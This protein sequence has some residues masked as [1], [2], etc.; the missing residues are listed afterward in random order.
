MGKLGVMAFQDDE[1]QPFLGYEIA[2]G[3]VY[4]EATAAQIDNEVQQLLEERYQAVRR[5][6]LSARPKLD[7][8]VNVLLQEETVAQ[9]RLVEILGPRPVLLPTAGT[10]TQSI[11]ARNGAPE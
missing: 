5:L 2:Q 8:L 6:L 1:H 4:S 11:A 7:R 10:A 3:R 9:E